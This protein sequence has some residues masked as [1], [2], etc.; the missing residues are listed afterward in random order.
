MRYGAPAML[1]LNR[2]DLERAVRD[3]ADFEYV[4]FYGH[5]P[6]R[7]ESLGDGCFSQWYESPF[8]VD[9]VTYPTAE[10]WMM[11]SKARLFSDEATLAEVLASK[12][13]A[14]A[15]K[16]GRQVKGF[17]EGRWKDRRFDLVTRGNVAKFS[18]TPALRAYLL[19][20]GDTVLVEAAL[21]DPIWGIGLDAQH[22]AARDPSRWKGL[23][24]LGFALMRARAILQGSLP[25]PDGW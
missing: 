3:G 25:T 17:N 23:N 6:P 22:P 4:L 10:H 8:T 15:K 18:S 14:A 20:T 19:A 7:D 11:A 5:H 16:L 12:T 21:N 24:L 2:Y 9:G 1:T 13:P